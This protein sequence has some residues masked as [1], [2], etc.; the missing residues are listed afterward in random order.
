MVFWVVMIFLRLIWLQVVEHRHYRIRAAHQHTV[1]VP[2][3]PI[4][5]ELRDRRGG[6][7]AISLKVDSL[8][9]TPPA[10]YPDYRAA[11]DD[12]GRFWG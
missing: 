3:E 12:N 6:S 9:C 11:K 5:G 4:R 8:F 10:F 1:T 7:L 2:I